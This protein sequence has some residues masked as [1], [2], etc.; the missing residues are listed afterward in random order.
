MSTQRFVACAVF[1]ALVFATAVNK[2]LFTNSPAPRA[3]EKKLAGSKIQG[4]PVS[5]AAMPLSNG[6]LEEALQALIKAHDGSLTAPLL[7]G[8]SYITVS[9]PSSRHTDYSI[10]ISE[11]RPVVMPIVH[12]DGSARTSFVWS[13]PAAEMKV[14][15]FFLQ[16][17]G[18]NWERMVVTTDRLAWNGRVVPFKTLELEKVRDTLLSK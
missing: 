15:H 6:D 5:E 12:S 1:V 7:E 9:K 16:Q 13:G 11:E 18:Q 14:L 10:S 17:K 8:Y 2:S 4:T 3:A